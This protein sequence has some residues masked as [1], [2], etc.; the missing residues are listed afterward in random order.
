[1][2]GNT[3]GYALGRGGIAFPV[4]CPESYA[5]HLTGKCP[6]ELVR[7]CIGLTEKLRSPE[8][9]IAV[10]ARPYSGLHTASE[11]KLGLASI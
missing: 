3:D 1:M 9:C 6:S 11:E 5:W 10:N 4:F 7:E 2:E 8:R